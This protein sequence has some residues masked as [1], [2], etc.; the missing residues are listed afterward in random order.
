MPDFQQRDGVRDGGAAVCPLGAGQ[1]RLHDLAGEIVQCGRFAASARGANKC[2][3]TYVY[4]RSV[5]MFSRAMNGSH[6]NDSSRAFV[7][8]VTWEN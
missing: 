2:I 3:P 5:R 1:E 6:D 8:N 4:P 7:K